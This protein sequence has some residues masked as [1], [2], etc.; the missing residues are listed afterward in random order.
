MTAIDW[1]IVA[2][3]V[4]LAFYGYMQG[5]IVGVMSLVGFAIGAF[6]GTRLGPLLLPGGSH[7]QYAPL[8]GLVGALLAGGVLA[9]GFEGIG[10]AARRTLR[11]PGLRA[12]DGLFGA[13]LTACVGLG[14]AW[15]VGAI[16]LQSANNQQLRRDIQQSAILG[17]LNDLLPPSGPILHALAR[18]DPLPSVRGPAA[19]VKAP[20]RGI[21]AAP[22]V[23]AA[24]GSVVRIVGTAC[25]LG[26][27]GSGWIAAPGL[28][29]TNAHV[30]A[31]E[32]DEVAQPGGAAPGI[33]AEAVAFDPHN[34][35]AVLR[36]TGLT[37]RPLP[38][39]SDPRPGTAAA[40]LGY[41]LDGP[42]DSEPGRIGQTQDVSTEDAYG[43]GPVVR[44]ITSLRGLVRPGN[45]GGPMVDKAE[46][47]VATV[48]AAITSGSASGPGGFAVPNAIVRHE[49]AVAKANAG[50]VSTG[51]C[52][53]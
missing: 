3:T 21:V 50:P 32:T 48:F 1:L 10:V 52:A 41:P 24:H 13:V 7:S 4:L 39:A 30:V 17:E 38:L 43:N 46:S 27:E 33:P 37:G 26:I 22:A 15:I 31:G 12:V 29:V 44:T 14:I 5:F 42:F 20:P 49:L 47:V 53:G 19:Q 34:D 45:S 6:L 18:F 9:S 23:V 40:I 36:V 11:L 2:F 25:G 51:A 8:F 28:V 35:V 16:A